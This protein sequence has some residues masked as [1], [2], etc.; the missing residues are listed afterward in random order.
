VTHEVILDALRD[1]A[2]GRISAGCHGIIFAH[3][4]ILLS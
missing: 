3:T 2:A 4:A 1:G